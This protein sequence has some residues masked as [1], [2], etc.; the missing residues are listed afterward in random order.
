MNKQIVIVFF[1][2]TFNNLFCFQELAQKVQ[3]LEQLK[4]KHEILKQE[5][6]QL[7]AQCD[8]LQE[9]NI[10]LQ[11]YNSAVTALAVSAAENKV[12]DKRVYEV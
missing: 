6:D 8:Q 3:Q 4:V 2:L 10:F 11:E 5:H 9:E 12:S 1:L 7:I